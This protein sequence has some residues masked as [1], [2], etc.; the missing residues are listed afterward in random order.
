MPAL[1]RPVSNPSAP[2][3]GRAGKRRRRAEYGHRPEAGGPVPGAR[4]C[5]T[6]SPA[7]A[8]RRRA[9]AWSIPRLPTVVVKR[10]RGP[11]L[12]Q[13]A[14]LSLMMQPAG[15]ADR[16]PLRG[17]RLRVPGLGASASGP[18]LYPACRETVPGDAVHDDQ[19]RPAARGPGHR[20]HH[21]RAIGPDSG[22]DRLAGRAAARRADQRGSGPGPR[23]LR[24]PAC[25]RPL[26]PRAAHPDFVRAA[27]REPCIT[28]V[29]GAGD[30]ALMRVPQTVLPAP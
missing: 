10:L 16:G 21:R 1:T 14:R 30:C 2:A 20:R 18:A 8:D 12:G 9:S 6:R 4:D 13:I 3:A 25:R 24:G 17:G 27:L 26:C 29:P 28:R 5:R 15:R 22:A 19:R 23:R 7:R 11:R